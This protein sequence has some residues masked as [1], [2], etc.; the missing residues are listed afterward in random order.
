MSHSGLSYSLRISS[1]QEFE[2]SRVPKH[3]DLFANDVSV[4]R[5]PGHDGLAF[6]WPGRTEGRNIVNISAVRQKLAWR[7]A[8]KSNN[9]Y[10]IEVSALQVFVFNRGQSQPVAYET[11]WGVQVWHPLWDQHLSSNADLGIGQKA[12]W[13]ADE[14]YLFPA[15]EETTPENP[16]FVAGS[17]FSNLIDV[18]ATVEAIAL[19]KEEG[20]ECT[21]AAWTYPDV[22]AEDADSD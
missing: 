14:S 7:F 10:V 12:D 9:D 4:C 15:V 17:G 19:G 6:G 5:D 20:K 21:Q 8:L 11:R 22:Y 13:F 16:L 2:E 18:L 3:L 1:A